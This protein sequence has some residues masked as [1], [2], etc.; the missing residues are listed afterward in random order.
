[1]RLFLS[2][3]L[4]LLVSCSS[5][6]NYE[7]AELLN[8]SGEKIVDLQVEIADTEARQRL[9]LMYRKELPPKTGMVFLF[10]REEPRSFWMK[11]TF[12]EL[13]IIFFNANFELVSISKRATPLTESRRE[14]TGPAKYVLEVIGGSSDTWGLKPGYRL[15]LPNRG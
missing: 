4:L 5:K 9:G 8:S 13:D 14:S 3:L 7:P 2:L 6:T 10:D 1:M 12:V 11:N 15:R